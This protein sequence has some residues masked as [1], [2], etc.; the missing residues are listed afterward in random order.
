MP[1]VSKT[2]G[3]AVGHS[4]GGAAAG[5]VGWSGTR[6]QHFGQRIPPKGLV[7]MATP[8]VPWYP[9]VFP[10]LQTWANAGPK[11]FSK[12]LW[13]KRYLLQVSTY[14]E[15]SSCIAPG[16]YMG[17]QY[18][19]RLFFTSPGREIC[20]AGMWEFLPFQVLHGEL[21]FWIPSPLVTLANQHSLTISEEACAVFVTP[22]NY[23]VLAWIHLLLD[24]LFKMKTD[25]KIYSKMYIAHKTFIKYY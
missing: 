16:A 12:C 24:V 9:W 22:L 18:E 17:Q 2:P 14:T 6:C 1:W 11:E 4:P 13:R 23:F 5:K 7:L 8:F 21:S 25:M 10:S 3:L 15:Q 19:A 20:S